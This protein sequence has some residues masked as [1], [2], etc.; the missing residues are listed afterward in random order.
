M[1]GVYR[2]LITSDTKVKVSSMLDKSVGKKHLT[3][4]N[5]ETCWTSQQGLPQFIQLVFPEPV[6]PRRIAL[7]FQGGFVG[8]QCMIKVAVSSEAPVWTT[9]TH[10]HPE[11]VNRR[12]IFE[13]PIEGK[14][15]QC[16]KLVFEK[17]S[18][19]F[20]RVTIYELSIEGAV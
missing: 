2:P 14:D 4:G 10:I 6:L 9:W 12:Q 7:T 5:P 17:S 20:G 8:I 18:D 11:D 16:M 1:S 19:F 13:L 3:D 15:I